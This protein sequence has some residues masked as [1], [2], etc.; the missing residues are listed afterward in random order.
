MSDPA[1]ALQNKM[2]SAFSEA[3][4]MGQLARKPGFL[5]ARVDQIATALHAT[6]SPI[7]TL[8]QSELLIVLDR[9]GPIPQITLARAAGLDKSTNGH[10]LDNMQGRGWIERVPCPDD[11][12]RALITL[13]DDGKA[14]LPQVRDD[15]EALQDELIAPIADVDQARLLAML[16]RL[17]ANPL[18]PA[19]LWRIESHD[20]LDIFDNALSFL[21][22]RALQHLQATFA[23]GAQDERTTLRQFA[24]LFVVAARGPITQT[25]IA[26]LYGLDP[27]TCA[28]ILRVLSKRRWLTSERS[29]EDGRERVHKITEI[30]TEAL[31]IL[32][33]QAE[34]LARAAMRGESSTDRRWLVE[35]LRL[36]VSS[37]SH[38]LRF[39][40]LLPI[41][42]PRA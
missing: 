32:Q 25:G 37:T 30:G 5:L 2:T 41:N 3:E 8:A 16:H 19:P 18:S 38:L 23:A 11:R 15:F 13:T 33:E 6:R 10:V 24:L 35:Q 34:R 39:P 7:A 22:R 14:V 40:G 36:I 21:S 26:R 4:V 12:R 1:V 29:A 31:T 17:G 9:I 20:Q 42:A 27:S 28:V